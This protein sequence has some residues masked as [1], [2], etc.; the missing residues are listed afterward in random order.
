LSLRTLVICIAL[1]SVFTMAV[2]VSAD[3]DTWWHLAAGRWMVENR[4]LLTTDPFSLTRAGEAWT[5]PSWLAQ[6]L[7]YGTYKLGGLPGLNV[8][9]ALMVTL[10]FACTWPVM[11]GPGLLRAFVLVGAAAVSGIYWSARPQIVSFALTGACLLV[12]EKGRSD[13]KWWIAVPVLLALWANIHGGFIIGLML[14]GICLGGELIEAVSDRLASGAAW[15]MLWAHRKTA[16]LTL[17]ALLL[18]SAAFVSFNPY[19]P[20]LLTYPVQTVSIGTLQ[21]A[22]DEWQSPD[23]HRQDTLPFLAMLLGT[24]LLIALSPRRKTGREMLL[25][26]ALAGLALVARRNIALFALCLAPAV[27]QHAW[28]ILESLIRTKRVPDPKAVQP[29]A[30]RLA[31]LALLGLLAAAAVVKMIEPL[32]VERNVLAVRDQQPLGAIAYMK[33]SRPAGPLFNSYTWGGYLIWD[34]WPEYLTYVDGRT[35]LFDDQVLSEYL[36]VWNGDEGW[37]GIL[38]SRGVQLALLEPHA[39]VVDQMTTAGWALLHADPQA[40]LLAAPASQ[41]E[42]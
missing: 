8:L 36:T 30:A 23:F 7:L 19:G 1:L 20:R 5:N 6:L 2:R 35:D 4:Q 24:M 37:E 31:N 28:A 14:V 29:P 22:I 34:V 10:A 39:P 33:E 27:A 16:V 42:N 26:V 40:V 18:A 15:R 21:T 25:F 32:S 12:L 3:T 9:T 17:L 13:R 41:D 38:R 11:A